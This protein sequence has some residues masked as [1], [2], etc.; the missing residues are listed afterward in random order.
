MPLPIFGVF[1]MNGTLIYDIFE[2]CE[3]L[4]KDVS[5]LSF[6]HVYLGCIRVV[7]H[8]ASSCYMFINIIIT[9]CRPMRC[10]GINNYFVL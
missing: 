6:L 3:L 10:V 9:S 4:V 8:F 2:G 7:H 5:F 1:G